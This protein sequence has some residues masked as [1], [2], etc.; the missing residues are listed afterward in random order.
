MDE[1]VWYLRTLNAIRRFFGW[2]ERYYITDHEWRE[3]MRSIIPTQRSK[4]CILT[5]DGIVK[6][7]VDG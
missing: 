4:E 2:Q 6:E 5:S 7:K 3:Y 1:I